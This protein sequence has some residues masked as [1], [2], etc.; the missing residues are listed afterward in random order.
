LSAS[1][2]A[3]YDI[4][5]TEIE[6]SVMAW[7]R[8]ALELRQGEAG[9]PEGRIMPVH[10]SEGH[11]AV[12]DMLARVRRRSDRIDELLAKAT[13]AK[14]RAKRT[15]DQAKFDAE[16]AYDTAAN[17]NANNRAPERMVSREERHA[18]A[19]LL[20]LNERRRAHQA[21][22]LVSITTEAHRL[23]SDASWQLGDIRKELREIIHAIQ[24]ESSLER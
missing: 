8:E 15:Q 23:I 7:A 2:L 4:P 9:D 12:L 20:S 18:D 19:A 22:R 21:E 14:A 13:M 10:I 16:V 24:F 1:A 3:A 11:R 6:S 5:F 17:D